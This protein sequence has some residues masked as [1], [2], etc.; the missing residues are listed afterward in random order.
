MPPSCQQTSQAISNSSG[1]WVIA[2]DSNPSG[3][4]GVVIGRGAV[5]V[6]GCARLRVPDAGRGGRPGGLVAPGGA[7]AAAGGGGAAGDSG[8]AGATDGSA[9]GATRRGGTGAAVAMGSAPAGVAG[10]K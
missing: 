10:W 2:A 6:N 7:H 3:P 1:G 4:G 5:G 9:D 8:A